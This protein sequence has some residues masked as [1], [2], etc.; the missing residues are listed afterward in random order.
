MDYELILQDK[1]K[2]CE[3]YTFSNVN[4]SSTDNMRRVKKDLK[5]IIQLYYDDDEYIEDSNGMTRSNIK[6]NFNSLQEANFNILN[7]KELKRKC[8]V[9]LLNF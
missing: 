1:Y 7:N 3:Y 4:A 5:H 6:R 2:L 9:N 8:K